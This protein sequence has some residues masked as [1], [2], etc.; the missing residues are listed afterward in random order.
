MKAYL[1]NGLEK[2]YRLGGERVLL[3]QKEKLTGELVA[4]IMSEVN[5]ATILRETCF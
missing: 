1:S 3:S 4:D 2:Y 5:F